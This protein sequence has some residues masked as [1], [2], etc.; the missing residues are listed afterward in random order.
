MVPLIRSLIFVLTCLLTTFGLTCWRRS[1][2]RSH[3]APD[4]KHLPLYALRYL[5]HDLNCPFNQFMFCW[6][7]LIVRCGTGSN[8]RS[9]LAPDA[10][11]IT[12]IKSSTPETMSAESHRDRNRLSTYTAVIEM[13]IGRRAEHGAVTRRPVAMPACLPTG[14][15]SVR[16]SS[17]CLS[18]QL[19]K[20]GLEGVY[21]LLDAPVGGLGSLPELSAEL[22]DPLSPFHTSRSFRPNLNARCSRLSYPR[23]APRNPASTF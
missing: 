6:S 1:C 17:T 4:L 5:A 23:P 20:L 15:S 7:V 18:D 22:R 10:A 13:K 11:S 9:M 16:A 21:Y 12:P 3:A 8:L 14:T 19:L 2:V